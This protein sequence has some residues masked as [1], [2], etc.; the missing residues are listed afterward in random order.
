MDKIYLDDNCKEIL[1][2]IKDNRYENDSNKDCEE[3]N[4][5]KNLGL[6]NATKTLKGYIVIGLTDKG[7]EYLY[8]NPNLKNP[9]IWD[10]KKYWIT[11]AI[12]IAALIVSII[13]LLKD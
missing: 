5:L 4:I 11:T 13:A 2:E 1:K 12:S 8:N 6:I 3:L 9:S 7:R 10:D